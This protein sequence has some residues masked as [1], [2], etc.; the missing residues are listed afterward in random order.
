MPTP[1]LSNCEKVVLP[2]QGR[3][4]H[5]WRPDQ[6]FEIAETEDGILLR[7][8]SP[9][10]DTTFDEVRGTTGYDGPR[11]STD[12]LTGTEAFRRRVARS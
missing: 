4:A 5:H 2:Q 8:C 9:F 10:P 7:P 12:Q 3:E 11:V 1:R 6:E